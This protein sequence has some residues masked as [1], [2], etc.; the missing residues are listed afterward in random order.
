[1]KKLVFIF[2]IV[3][4]SSSIL[5]A[6]KFTIGIDTWPPF[7]YFEN[8]KPK[9]IA[10]DIFKKL[11]K[12]LNYEIK[13]LKMPWQRSLL[14][15]KN[16]NIDAIGDL[17]YSKEREKF[18][19]Y[20]KYP[21]YELQTRFYTLKGNKHIISE[22]SDLYKYLILAGK[23]ILYFPKFDKDKKIKKEEIISRITKTRT[24]PKE[25]IMLKML[26]HKRV[27][28]IIS[29]NAIMNDLIEKKGYQN[30]IVK[31]NYAPDDIDKLFIG[32]SRK[33]PFIKDIDKINEAMKK[34]LNK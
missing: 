20:T 4:Y 6:E 7:V 19:L 34:I 23:D 10:I 8:K 26:M 5:N 33:S 12:E 2:L 24:I 28:V 1:M 21:F 13:F 14:E 27:S 30:N 15:L 11:G 22:Y 9:G 16:G 29:S 32:I 25:E 18:I 17:S 31:T 3:L